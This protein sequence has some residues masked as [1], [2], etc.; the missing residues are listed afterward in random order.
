MFRTSLSQAGFKLVSLPELTI[1]NIFA[2]DTKCLTDSIL[3]VYHILYDQ[4]YAEKWIQHNFLSY[5][6]AL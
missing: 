2:S 1:Y 4:Q 3:R 5:K 6:M